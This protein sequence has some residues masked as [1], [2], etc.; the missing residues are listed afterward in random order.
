MAL[1]RDASLG[2]LRLGQSLPLSGPH[3]VLGNAYRTAAVA[4]FEDLA[5]QAA[6]GPRVELISLDDGGQPERTAVNVKLLASEYRV[7]AAFGF[8]GGGADRVGSRAAAVEGLPY[9]APVS[10]SIEL[11][12]AHSPGT[13]T[14]RAS[15][16]DE[17]RYIA[18]HVE[19]IGLTRLALVCEYNFLG[20]ELR[21]TV[22]ELIEA[23]RQR[24]VVLTSIDREGS[25]YSVPG[26]VEAALAKQPQ[27]VILGANAVAAAAFIRAARAAGFKGY[28]YAL[29]SVGTQGLGAVLGPLVAGVSVTQVVPFVLSNKTVV[30]RRHRAFCARHG[31]APSSHSMEA[32]LAATL[33]FES[34]KRLRS[35]TPAAIAEAL[36]HSPPLDFGD[37][38][39]QWYASR[40]NPK[41]FVSL[42]VYDRNGRL[43]E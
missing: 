11:R 3:A 22:L 23:G 15:H 27:A 35:V 24:D 16:A 30:T 6:N 14:F 5:G 37:F 43:I 8:V 34:A 18:R 42:A 9:V 41:A 40:P 7:K 25:P 2:S 17:I 13:F 4:A 20:W 32:W 39:G 19:T 1:P 38:T 36:T 29:S 31:I 33:F 21:D 28:F 10:G 26:A 12:S